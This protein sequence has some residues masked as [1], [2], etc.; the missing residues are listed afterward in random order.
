MKIREKFNTAR[1]ILKKSLLERNEE[2]DLVMHG[3]LAGEHVLLVGPPGVAKSMLVDGMIHWLKD[4]TKASILLNRNTEPDEL[5]GPVSIKALSEREYW[6]ETEGFAPSVDILFM[7]EIWEG[8]SSANNTVLKILNE[9]QFRNG[10]KGMQACPLKMCLAASNIWP[11]QREGGGHDLMALYDRFLLRKEVKSLDSHRSWTLLLSEKSHTPV[12]PEDCRLSLEELATAQSELSEIAL[13]SDNLE[14]LQKIR[15]GLASNEIHVS[16]RRWFKAMQ[17]L[18]ASA[19]LA[20]RTSINN[21]DMVHLKHI[22]WTHYAN[23]ANKT[24]ECI[25]NIALP[26]SIELLKIDKERNEID[27]TISISDVGAIQGGVNKLKDLYKRLDNMKAKD[28]ENAEIL[29]MIEKV[30]ESAARLR[31]RGAELLAVGDKAA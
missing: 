24:F 3:L 12:F 22:L 30:R 20:G 5:L 31:A 28:P 21:D 27:E 14:I 23:E 6:R 29:A 2:I 16:P 18:R 17:V 26:E 15:C 7:D 4:A 25:T 11:Y 1:A 13:S 19:W 8:S 10:S 9:R